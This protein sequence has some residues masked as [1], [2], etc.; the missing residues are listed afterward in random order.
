MYL[1]DGLHCHLINDTDRFIDIYC[2]Y[3]AKYYDNRLETILILY[4]HEKKSNSNLHFGLGL[5]AG[6]D[7]NVI[8]TV[9]TVLGFVQI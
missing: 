1:Y 5:A 9:K 8:K 3:R 4:G 6:I 2:V 7:Q